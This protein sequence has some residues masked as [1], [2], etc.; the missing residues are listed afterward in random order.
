LSITHRSFSGEGKGRRSW[1][2]FK[3]LSAIRLIKQR[4]KKN[5]HS[6]FSAGAELERLQ[7]VDVLFLTT[8]IG[9]QMLVIYE[10]I[11]D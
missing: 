11:E 2:S 9:P 4:N 5:L 6:E 7:S 8:A 3:V 10:C 1:P